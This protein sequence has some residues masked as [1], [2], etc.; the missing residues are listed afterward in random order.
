M[1]SPRILAAAL[2]CCAFALPVWAEP[3]LQDGKWEITTQLQ[4]PGLPFAPPPMK[5]TRCLTKKDA[6]PQQNEPQS[7]CR[8][9]SSD[10]Q[11]DTVFWVMECKDQHGTTRSNGQVTYHKDSF[12]GAVNVTTSGKD[13]A[14]MTS[15]MSGRRLGNCK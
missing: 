6:V 12:E 2:L 3:N 1:T 7:N 8:M 13:A 14:T 11:G 15:K 4:M 9:I 5:F 10:V